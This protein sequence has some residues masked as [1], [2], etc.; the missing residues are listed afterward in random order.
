MK[1]IENRW[2]LTVIVRQPEGVPLNRDGHG[3]QRKHNF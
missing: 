3:I 2:T 1:N